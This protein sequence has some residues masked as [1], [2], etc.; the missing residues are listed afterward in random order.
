M[1]ILNIVED[2]FPIRY[3]DFRKMDSMDNINAIP[4]RSISFLESF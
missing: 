4:V 2:F 3:V 1:F